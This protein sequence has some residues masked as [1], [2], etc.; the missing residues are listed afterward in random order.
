[1]TTRVHGTQWSTHRPKSC[2][3]TTT[4][5]NIF[6]TF[7][8]Q[9]PPTSTGGTYTMLECLW[10]LPWTPLP[11]PRSHKNRPYCHS[12]LIVKLALQVANQ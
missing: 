9:L 12:P 8:L 3:P 1:M 11:L 2:A 5:H 10:G 4:P 7:F 6:P